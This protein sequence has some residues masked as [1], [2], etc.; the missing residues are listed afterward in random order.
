MLYYPI[1]YDTNLRGTSGGK[2]PHS[3]LTPFPEDAVY[4]KQFYLGCLAQASYWIGSEEIAAVVDPQREVDQYVGRENAMKKRRALSLCL[5]FVCGCLLVFF[6]FV[7]FGSEK[8]SSVGYKVINKISIGG[9]G[10]WDYLTV[11]SDSRRLFISRGTRVQVVDIEKNA[12]SGEIPDTPGVHGIALAPDLHRGFTSNGRDASVTVFDLKTLAVL[13]TIKGTGTNPDAILYDAVSHRVFTFN[14]GSDDATAIDAS[15]SK[16]VGTIP[17]GGKP[18]F[19]VADAKGR[20]YVN[21]EDKSSLLSFDSRTLK[22]E[23]RWRLAPCEEPSGLAMD[24]DHRR[25]FAGCGNKLMAVVDADTGHVV[26]TLPIGRGVDANIFDPSSGLAFSSNG[27]GTLTVV[28][29]DS[30]DK[31]TVVENVATQR[32]ARTMAL[33]EKT[34]RLYLVTAEFSPPPAPTPGNPRP[35]PTMVPGSFVVLVLGR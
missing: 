33:D 19:A 24:R 27:D 7:L 31:F 16:V 4:L 2:N 20:I 17:L 32:G 25:L 9:E 5:L 13:N 34:H 18:E 3:T 12:L 28:R 15:S 21:I 14:G 10:S 8:T 26:T 29:E 30:P 6:R 11:D 35:R 22:I 1:Q 23:G